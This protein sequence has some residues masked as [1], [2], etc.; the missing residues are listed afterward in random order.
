MDIAQYM[1]DLGRGARAA[2]RGM[3]RATTAEKNRALTAIATAL[4]DS[5]DAILAANGE[6]GNTE[7][8]AAVRAKVKD[9]C[10]R[11]PIYQAL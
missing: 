6:D 7:V 2:S 3:A 1:Q 9:L 11:Y 4:N 8:E 10:D 5:R